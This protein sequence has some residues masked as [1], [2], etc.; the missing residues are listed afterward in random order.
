MSSEKGKIEFTKDNIDLYLKDVAKEYRRLVGKGMPAEIVII[1]GAS[2]LINY[3]FRDMTTDI[4]AVINAASAMK[5]AIN[6]IGDKHGLPNGW[7][8]ADFKKTGSFSSKILQY[9]VYYRTYA[10]VLTIRTVSAEYLVAMKLKSGRRYKHDIIDGFDDKPSILE[11]LR[12]GQ[13]QIEEE[14]AKRVKKKVH[15]KN[16]ED[17][18]E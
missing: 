12:R 6:M 13:K 11:A 10:N 9:S 14:D 5:D 1:G 8:N 3:G 4:D 18:I 16:R 17:V 7:L 15:Q 2:V